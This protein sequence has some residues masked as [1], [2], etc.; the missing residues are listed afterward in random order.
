M[1]PGELKRGKAGGK[2]SP[3]YFFYGENSVLI[4]EAIASIQSVL[5]P[6]EVPDLDL[7]NYDAQTHGPS[8]I[9]QSSRMI[10][11]S[12]P[13]KMVVVK[14][15][16]AFTNDQWEKFQ[17]Y[18][19][20]PSKYCCLVFTA[21]KLCLSGSLL[22]SFKK[23]GVS[24]VFA[25]PRWERDI[26]KVVSDGLKKYGKRIAPDALSYFVDSVGRDAQLIAKELEKTAL[27]C[28]DKKTIDVKDLEDILS[29]GHSITVFNL[30]D[31][32]GLGN[33]ERSLSCLNSLLNEGV[34]PLVIL[35][36]IARQ[37]RLISRA[38]EGLGKGAAAADIGRSLGLKSDF[39]VKGIMQ[40]ARG[41]PGEALGR[42][43]EEVF[44][45]N[46]MIKSSRIKEKVILEN[47]VFNLIN[48]R[49]QPAA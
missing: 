16:H 30:V 22:K 13:Q 45:S 40:Q 41:W 36:M 7:K 17:R 35:K 4:E 48:L 19:S 3:L 8:E 10:P 18:F 33:L 20:N 34:Y 28:T 42:V 23:N 49:N 24:T 9:I 25:N 32:I 43:F 46:Y 14:R 15:A 44:Q 26:K 2:I 39:I 11:F 21:D 27:Y 38:K 47:L 31:G 1:C 6:S 5:F 29:G 12:A 37:F